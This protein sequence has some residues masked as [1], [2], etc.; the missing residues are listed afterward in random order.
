MIETCP[1]CMSNNKTKAGLNKDKKQRYKCRTCGC[2]FTR[3][4]KKGSSL[5]IKRR[6]VQLY[7]EGLGF[8]SI[9][10]VLNVSNVTILK[11]I[12]KFGSDLTDL[13]PQSKAKI[14][15]LPLSSISYWYRIKPT[16]IEPS[17]VLTIHLN[18]SSTTILGTYH[19]APRKTTNSPKANLY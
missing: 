13:V 3:S 9:S 11:W 16:S 2:H 14:K 7:L 10:R 17:L 4:T 12:K 5:D 6:A 1:K 15:V 19:I 18:D 8:R